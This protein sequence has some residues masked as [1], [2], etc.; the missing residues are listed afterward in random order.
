MRRKRHHVTTDPSRA[1]PREAFLPDVVWVE[2]GEDGWMRPVSRTADP[3]GWRE[4]VNTDDAIVTQVDDGAADRGFWPTSSF[5]ALWLTRRVHDAA[6]IEPGMRVLEIGTGTG[7]NAAVM[8]EAGAH[9]V[10]VEID[11]DLA[12]HA[13]RALTA[14][15]YAT[16]VTV[17]TGDGEHGVPRHAPYDRVVATAAVHT[18]P[19]TWVNQTRDGGRIIVPYTGPAALGALLAL[20]VRD[21]SAEGR[22]VAEAAFMPVRGQRLNQNGLPHYEDGAELSV[23]VDRDGTHVAGPRTDGIPA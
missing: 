9:V 20:D 19:Y 21:G 18:V 16:G 22:A 6:A 4:A 7:Y 8:A 5:T 2:G 15:G 13:R 23:R 1:V 11:A 17:V 10:S 3:D 12:E 14:T